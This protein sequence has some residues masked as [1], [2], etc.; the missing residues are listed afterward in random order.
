[1]S[2]A[3]AAAACCAVTDF[4]SGPTAH[5]VTSV[6]FATIRLRGGPGALTGR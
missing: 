4:G 3:A 1:M 6:A 2:G 5:A